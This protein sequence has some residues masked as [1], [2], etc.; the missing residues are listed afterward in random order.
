[1]HACTKKPFANVIAC[2]C[3]LFHHIFAHMRVVSHGMDLDAQNPL[4]PIASV[5]QTRSA[6]ANHS[7]I[8]RGTKVARTNANRAIRVAAQRTQG[9]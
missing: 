2:A 3:A 4:S 7:A 1:M 6:L 8:P 9:L 5:Q